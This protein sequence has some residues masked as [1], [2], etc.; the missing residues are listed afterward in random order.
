MNNREYRVPYERFDPATRSAMEKARRKVIITG[1]ML[2]GQGGE[3][4]VNKIVDMKNP[5]RLEEILTNDQALKKYAPNGVSFFQKDIG[6]PQ[7]WSPYS[8][9]ER[10]YRESKGRQNWYIDPA[11]DPEMSRKNLLPYSYEMRRP[12]YKKFYDN[13][14]NMI[15]IGYVARTTDK[16]AILH[17]NDRTQRTVRLS[18]LSARDRKAAE[19]QQSW[20]DH[21]SNTGDLGMSGRPTGQMLPVP[22]HLLNFQGNPTMFGNAAGTTRKEGR[23][24]KVGPNG[25]IMESLAG[26]NRGQS[27]FVS[28]DQLDTRG[29]GIAYE[30]YESAK[31]QQKVQSRRDVRALRERTSRLFPMGTTD[32]QFNAM[33]NSMTDGELRNVYNRI[34]DKVEEEREASRQVAEG[35]RQRK[36]GESVVNRLNDPSKRQQNALDVNIAKSYLKQFLNTKLPASKLREWLDQ[37]KP[38]ISV[39]RRNLV[40]ELQ[41]GALNDQ[42]NAVGEDVPASAG[43]RETATSKKR[44]EDLKARRDKAIAARKARLNQIYKN[45]VQRYGKDKARALME[46]Q[47]YKAVQYLSEGGGVKDIITAAGSALQ[48]VGTKR[49]NPFTA[50]NIGY[51]MGGHTGALIGE[52][53]EIIGEGLYHGAKHGMKAGMT[54]A[55]AGYGAMVAADFVGE[56][57]SLALDPAAAGK[58]YESANRRQANQGYLSNVGENLTNPGRAI[59]QIG[60]ETAGLMDDLTS[61]LRPGYRSPTDRSPG[62]RAQRRQFG[63]VI[64]AANGMMV[65]RGTDTVPAMLT[66]GEFVVN[67]R[68]AQANM[69]LLNSINNGVQYLQNGGVAGGTSVNL[70]AFSNVLKTVTDSLNLFNAALIQGAEGNTGGEAGGVNTNGIAAFTQNFGNFIQQLTDISERIPDQI[71]HTVNGTVNVN[72]AGGDAFANLAQESINSTVRRQLSAGFD[73]VEKDTEGQIK[74]PFK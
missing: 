16:E 19:T 17:M 18:T 56:A 64:Y 71:Q 20:S 37:T 33:N 65:P 54:S 21:M 44:A 25:V 9:E 51:G 63:G 45:F 12:D 15:G 30:L 61:V 8:F 40:L 35:E 47:G 2:S 31:N 29:R 53:G 11:F 22:K 52:A 14:G 24:L 70:D 13:N 5:N 55:A 34:K 74:N 72:V 36:I 66:P 39:F 3:S 43:R 41:R 27:G 49:G 7:K 32:R 67:R 46:K 59:M 4:A 50:R 10:E 28:Y 57:A 38:G 68:A 1:S 60:K 23:I 6:N 62:R 26:T 69:P 58:R 48:N 42:L 73:I